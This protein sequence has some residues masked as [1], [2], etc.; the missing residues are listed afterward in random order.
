M[1]TIKNFIDG[2]FVESSTKSFVDIVSP[3]TGEVIGKVPL[4]SSNELNDAITAAEKAFSSW[5]SLT[6]KQKI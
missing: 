6:I 4:C 3:S 5:S 2:K 1:A